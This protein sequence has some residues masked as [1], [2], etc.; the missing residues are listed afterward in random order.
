MVVVVLGHELRHDGVHPELR[1]R[2]D[3]AISL[4]KPDE[5]VVVTG[6]EVNEDIPRTESAVMAEY[7][8]ERGTPSEYVHGES[9]AL[10]TVGNAYF[11]R[12]LVDAL[13]EP[14]RSARHRRVRVVTSCYHAPR[15]LFLF[16]RCF[17]PER[18]VTTPV[19]NEV[20]GSTSTRAISE[21]R[22]QQLNERLLR[23]VRPGDMEHIRRRIEH[24]H[25]LYENLPAADSTAEHRR[26]VDAR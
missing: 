18:S 11:T 16:R 10:D 9:R 12:L 24:R 19:C 4:R 3:A 26:A 15:A 17:G 6:G 21:A 20:D 8:I 25:A 22:S 14:S 7:L 2:L 13:S 23:G 1:G 5:H